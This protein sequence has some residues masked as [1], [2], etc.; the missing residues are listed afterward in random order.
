[1]TRARLFHLFTFLVATGALV[2][3]AVLVWQGHS[4]LDESQRPDLATR[5]VRFVSYLTIW[6]NALVAWS[7]GTLAFGVDRDTRLWRALRLDAVV[8]CVGGGVVHFFL[9]RPLLDLDGADRLADVLLHNVVPLL[10]L[11]GWLWFGPRGRASRADLAPFLVLPVVWLLYTLLRGAFV[12]W[13]PYPFVDVVEHGY[14]VVLVNVLGITAFLVL[15]ALA[16]IALDER[17]S[18]RDRTEEPV[19]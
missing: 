13:Y 15:F 17:L 7:T 11:V 4:V 1:M 5:L 3:Q 18:Q 14:G 2:L 10:A 19:P 8:I 6:S 12:D 9:L 16:V